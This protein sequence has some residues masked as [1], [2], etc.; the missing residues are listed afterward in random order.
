MNRPVRVGLVGLGQMGRNHLRVLGMLRDADIAF[1]HD[2]DRKQAADVAAQYGV[3]AAEDVAAAARD[4][5]AVLVCTPTSTHADY[6][7]QLAPLVRFLFVEK[8]LTHSFASAQELAP[9]LARHGTWIQTGFIERFNPAVIGLRRVL[10]E[11][12]RVISIDFTRTNRLSARI[13]DVDVILDLM[14]HDI[15]LALHLNGPLRAL[16]AQGTVQDGVIEFASAQLTHANGRFSRV[17]ASRITEKKIRLVQATCGDRFVDCDLLRRE[18]VIHRQSVTQ[19][20]GPDAYR[21]SSQQ[22]SVV[23]GQQEALLSELQAFLA[24]VR[25]GAGVQQAGSGDLPDYA[26]GCASLRVCEEVRALILETAK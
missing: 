25:G 3:P 18:I 26:A 13:T 20:S 9:L 7:R 19:Q 10:Q 1:V 12:P 22:E 17:Q 5:D 8:P 23:V 15:D 21:I 24:V 2:A 16:A 6:I 4:V 14:V 11:S